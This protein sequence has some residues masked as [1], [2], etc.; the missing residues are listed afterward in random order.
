MS[1]AKSPTEPSIDEILATIRR[2]ISEDEQGAAASTG[3]AA[4]AAGAP[5]GGASGG[6]ATRAEIP[7]EK[8][9]ADKTD[10]GTLAD[11]DILELTE[12]LNEDGSTRHLAPIGGASSRRAASIVQAAAASRSEPPQPPR[13]APNLRLAPAASVAGV[14]REQREPRLPRDPP[15]GAGDRTL[16][17]IV[18]EVLR[19]LLQA[20]LDENLP[21]LVE[22]LV[23]AEI[24]RTAREA[25]A[26]RS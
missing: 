16:E 20:W 1:D 18:R 7:D 9:G 23:Q 6:G 2:I 15:I 14:A 11:D 10:G 4:A 5:A 12:A 22:R 21:P 13:E 8:G 25:G 24:A 26:T 19:P 17:D 3:R